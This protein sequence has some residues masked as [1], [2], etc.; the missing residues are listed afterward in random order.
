M[1]NIARPAKVWGLILLLLAVGATLGVAVDRTWLRS[2]PSAHQEERGHRG[3][4][5]HRIKRI[6]E[7]FKRRLNLSPEQAEEV[8]A[9]LHSVEDVAHELHESSKPTMK[10][11]MDAADER[12]RSLL[13]AEQAPIYEKLIAERKR[14]F[15]SS[16]G[17]GPRRRGPHKHRSR[18]PYDSD[19]GPR[20][21]GPFHHLD[22][23]GDGVLS[24]DEV[25]TDPSPFGARIL[26]RFTEIDTD[27]D[28]LLTPEELRNGRPKR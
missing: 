17:P 13:N 18:G 27:G 8:R 25:A 6:F 7:V 20:R 26:K 28:G 22:S 19:A 16:G 5:P 21:R 12:I 9:I 3:P 24:K 10:A 4:P 11:A 14:R 1:N 23:N 2:Q 15:E